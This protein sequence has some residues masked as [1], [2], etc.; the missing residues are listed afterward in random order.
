VESVTANGRVI[1]A[2]AHIS[3][4]LPPQEGLVPEPFLTR[5]RALSIALLAVAAS[6]L[7]AWMMPG[8]HETRL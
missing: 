6:L 1:Y 7:I 3:D 8:H 2:S 5:L 4:F